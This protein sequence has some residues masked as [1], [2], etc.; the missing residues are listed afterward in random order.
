MDE[1]FKDFMRG[2]QREVSTTLGRRCS[3]MKSKQSQ[4]QA[5]PPGT[6]GLVVQSSD[7]DGW[8]VIER[9]D[10]VPKRQVMRAT[11]LARKRLAPPTRALTRMPA[12]GAQEKFNY[13]PTWTNPQVPARP[14][15][16]M[17]AGEV[18]AEDDDE[19][20]RRIWNLPEPTRRAQA[21]PPPEEPALEPV[22]DGSETPPPEPA[23][24]AASVAGSSMA[25]ES[26]HDAAAAGDASADVEPA[27]ATPPAESHHEATGSA[28]GEEEES[29]DAEGVEEP[30]AEGH[31]EAE[32][33]V[34]SASAISE[35]LEAAPAAPLEPLEPLE[36]LD[37][38]S[39][40]VHQ[41]FEFGTDSQEEAAASGQGLSA[42]QL[43]ADPMSASWVESVA[44]LRL[45]ELPAAPPASAAS[46]FS[47]DARLPGADDADAS[48]SAGDG[49]GG[50]AGVAGWAWALLFG[51][52]SATHH[53]LVGLL[54]AHRPRLVYRHVFVEPHSRRCVRQ[55]VVLDALLFRGAVGIY[56]HALPALCRATL[57]VELHGDWRYEYA[58][59]LM[60]TLPAYLVCELVST[61]WHYKMAQKMSATSQL[62][63]AALRGVAPAA[64]AAGPHV[65]RAGD[66]AAAA[67]A[68]AGSP[69]Q[70]V[71]SV[72][73][74]RLVYIAFLLQIKLL[75]AMLPVP[76]LGVGVTLLLSAL[77][78]SYDC[79]EA[80]WGQQGKE[81]QQRFQLIEDHWMF[82]LGYG[83]LLATLS[84]LLRFWD[85]FVIRAILYPLYIANAP[86]ARFE[87]LRC[88]PLPAFQLAFGVI[89][90]GLQLVELRT[91]AV[92]AS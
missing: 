24:E 38:A 69:V 17:V 31:A 70:Q 20:Y 81:V 15:P 62:Y 73:Y 46:A 2:A 86:H 1:A 64:S 28:M 83:A 60:W 23:P 10:S 39:W 90:S 33:A 26:D 36:P 19:E 18:S 25:H 55:C 44:P 11:T 71:A 13:G 43:D 84:V 42:S 50:V 56:E 21:A 66:L 75:A 76:A 32:A 29:E 35:P 4:P 16:Y 48:G 74:T 37:V 8:D 6:A 61:S 63:R 92:G 45:D 51:L 3:G 77:V 67:A 52:V 72:V 89:N 12:A 88:R 85:L 9:L 82:F 78:H 54:Q 40:A 65:P 41:P 22:S 27:E 34:C 7:D 91:R 58:I 87:T 57:G 68:A 30:A 53:G 59:L 80:C 79:F 47:R 49:K 14:A 5:K